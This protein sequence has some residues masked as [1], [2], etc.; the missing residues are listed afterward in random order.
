MRCG[1]HKPVVASCLCR[2][3]R[4]LVLSISLTGAGGK[5]RTALDQ[6]LTKIVQKVSRCPRLTFSSNNL[7]CLFAGRHSGQLYDAGDFTRSIFA[8]E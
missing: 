7:W 6:N 1:S 2:R 5:E 3:R 4:L 8:R